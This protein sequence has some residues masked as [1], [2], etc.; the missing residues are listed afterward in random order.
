MKAFVKKLIKVLKAN[1]K[2]HGTYLFHEFD[3]ENIIIQNS[4]GKKYILY[5]MH[6]KMIEVLT[7]HT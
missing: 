2:S 5:D 7:P 1:N 6:K 3:G 4:D